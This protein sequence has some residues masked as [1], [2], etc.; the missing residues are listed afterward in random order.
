MSPPPSSRGAIGRERSARLLTEPVGPTLIRLALPMVVGLA[1]IILFTVVDTFFVGRLGATPLA[2]MSFCFPVNFVVYSVTMGI[3]IGTTSVISRAIGEGD[4]AR[5]R[6]L[7]T[8]ALVLALG[9]VTLIAGIGLVTMDPIFSAM[10]ADA[11]TLPLIREYMTPWLWGVGLLVIPMV[12]NSAI[13]ATGD[14]V[15]PSAI[16]IVAGVLNIAL[17]PILIF[18]LGPVP[19]LGLA[20]AAIA[21]VISWSVTFAAA[22]WLLVKRERMILFELPTAAELWASWR[23]ILYVGL[24]A[25]G[26]NL[27]VP[28]STGILT[29]FV[30]GYGTFAVA[31]FGVGG[32]MEALAMIGINAMATALT[33]F[34][35]QNYGA[36]NCDRIRA[37][38]GF[39]SKVALAWGGGAAVLLGL[40][41][42]PIARIFNDEPQVVAHCVDYMRFIPFSYGLLGI[43]MLVN[44]TFVALGRP[45]QASLVIGVR[46]FVLAIPL[47]WLG[48][49]LFDL[50][51]LFG[52]VA[53]GNVLACAFAYALV[54]RHLAVV[55]RQI[56]LSTAPP[57]TTEMTSTSPESLPAPIV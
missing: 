21:T 8:H 17:D 33:P 43:A 40:L 34:I 14:T 24:P 15:S 29:R 57:L 37:A 3:G 4:Q 26:T 1:A 27:L 48:S 25:A 10:G 23:A 52:G 51:G 39:G 41:A 42:V 12:G 2:A 50:R 46:L 22:S 19:A 20:G 31:A 53:I 38:L 55:E 5:V 45:L 32:R 16:M 47:A 36:G 9:T 54:R 30:A 18:G 56:A 49:T 13:R 28:L 6:R 11:T 35:G 7:T 44:T